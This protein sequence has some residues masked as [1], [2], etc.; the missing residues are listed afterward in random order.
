M[1]RLKDYAHNLRQALIDVTPDD[2][3]FDPRDVAEA[4][5][6]TMAKVIQLGRNENPF[7][8]S[9]R[10]LEAVLD[11][12]AN[13]YP[14]RSQFI[15]AVSSYA[16]FPEEN[17]IAGA[18]LDELIASICRLFLDPKDRAFVFIPTYPYYELQI[19]LCGA[20]PVFRPL[21]PATVI[22]EE[23]RRDYKLA[24]LCSPN[25]PTGDILNEV[26][27]K[28]VLESTEGIVFLDEAY[29]EFAGISLVDL[30]REHENLIVGRTLSKAFGLAG[31]RL[32]YAIAPEWIADQYR[33]CSPVFGISS[34]SLA[35]GVAALGDL[36][37]M[38]RCVARIVSERE[39][40]KET[41]PEACPSWGNFIY[42]ETRE[43][44]TTVAEDLLRKGI[45]VRDCASIPGCGDHHIRVTVGRPDENDAFLAAYL[46]GRPGLS[47]Q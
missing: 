43:R 17:V 23:L 16:G 1:I 39:R 22:Q 9:P 15:R 25:N 28:E 38:H 5:G 6:L 37:H 13:R 10:A 30:V 29:A 7:G 2:A 21:F 40:M 8:P 24:F 20:L 18:G 14:D 11:A 3:G 19:R 45:A 36:D 33:R 27:L 26:A 42:L 31:L 12:G 46:G 44:S 32:G 34:W 47:Q 4:S 41:L 35:A